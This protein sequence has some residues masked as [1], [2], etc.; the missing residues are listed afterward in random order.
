MVRGLVTVADGTIVI[1]TELRTDK[2]KNKLDKLNNDIER[3]ANKVHDLQ[4]EY[5]RL[6]DAL[7]DA[8]MAGSMVNPEDAENAERA[9]LEL[10]RAQIQLN[11]MQ[12][13]AAGTTEQLRQMQ[14]QQGTSG[15]QNNIEDASK[16]LEKF[17][18]KITTIAKKVFV[19]TLISS[20][21]RKVKAYMGEALEANTTYQNSLAQLRGTLRTAFQ[22]ILNVVIPILQALINILNTAMSYVAKFTSW[23]FGTTVSASAAAA[24]A[25]YNQANATE[26]AGNAAAKAKRQ[27]SG[28]DEM[29]TYQT[30]TGSSAGGSSAGTN[31]DFSAVNGVKDAMS[32]L[33]VYISGALLALGAILAFSG[34][35]IPLG[36]ALMAIG[37]A[38][39]ASA[40]SLDWDTMPDH[41]RSALTATLVVIGAASLAIG[42]I[43]AFSSPAH[44]ALGIGLIVAGAAALGTAM[45]LNWDTLKEKISGETAVLMGIIGAALLVIGM[46]LAVSGAMPLGIALIAAG[47][48]GLVTPIALNWDA[49]KDKI[50]QAWEKIKRWFKTNVAPKFTKKFW[51]EKFSTISDGLKQK[52]K[53]GI[54]AA[55][56]LFNKFISWINDKLNIKWSSV[57]IAGLEVIPK[58]S[59]QLLK[60]NSIPMLAQGGVIPANNEFLAVLGDQKRGNNIEA[61]ESLIRQIVREES[62]NGTYTFVAQLDGRTLFKEVISQGKLSRRMSGKNEFA[63]GGG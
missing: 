60:L 48:V 26:A 16:S 8:R 40:L 25:L 32:D 42:V 7:T 57:K 14:G 10:E 55:I 54:N 52:I 50:S 41:V 23:L 22:P 11:Q 17:Q 2:L 45:A 21:L 12:T 37:A 15:L 13:N 33:E 31:V 5:D 19:F 34:V 63:L 35:S 43:L 28:L 24:K 58:G 46:I 4:L 53:D 47:A 29:N 44:L 6:N 36:I 3:Q 61:P 18:K 9:R 62:G 56:T 38:G 20:A 59:F 51:L 49:L 27:M 30:D 1:N 39:L